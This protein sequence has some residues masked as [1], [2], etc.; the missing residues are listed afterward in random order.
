MIFENFFILRNGNIYYL[1]EPYPKQQS[2]TE[3]NY[4]FRHYF[5]RVIK[6]IDASMGNMIITTDTQILKKM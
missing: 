5:Q 6:T 3:N 1:L 4:T 2:L